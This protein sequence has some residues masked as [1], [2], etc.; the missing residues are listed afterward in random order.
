MSSLGWARSAWCPVSLEIIWCLSERC[1]CTQCS[2][3]TALCLLGGLDP[4]TAMD[5][6]I[7]NYTRARGLQG[8]CS[9]IPHF[10]VCTAPATGAALQLLEPNI[11]ELG[12]A[13]P[14]MQVSLKK[15]TD[16][17]KRFCWNESLGFLSQQTIKEA[18]F[19]AR[20]GQHPGRRCLLRS[21]QED[22]GTRNWWR[23]FPA[24]LLSVPPWR[25][26]PG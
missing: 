6:K 10:G 23:S 14:A 9:N 5:S 26:S 11:Q 17:H 24:P 4:K 7:A 25:V 2:T 15:S 3:F 22:T 1:S 18:V 16:L 21:C 8:V 13:L 20:P 19:P 12:L